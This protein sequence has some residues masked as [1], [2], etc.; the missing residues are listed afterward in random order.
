MYESFK[1]KNRIIMP[2]YASKQNTS[3]DYDNDIK[4]FFKQTPINKYFFDTGTVA[5]RKIQHNLKI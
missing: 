1:P 2:N 3:D 4:K 5:S